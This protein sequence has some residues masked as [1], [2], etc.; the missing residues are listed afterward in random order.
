MCIKR[1]RKDISY[2]QC[3]DLIWIQVQNKLKKY[4]MTGK[5]KN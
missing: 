3:M 1:N 2:Y 5:Y 4:M